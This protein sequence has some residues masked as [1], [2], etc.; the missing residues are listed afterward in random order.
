[1]NLSPNHL[2]DYTQVTEEDFNTFLDKYTPNYCKIA[3]AYGENYKN[4]KNIIF[5]TRIIKKGFYINNKYI[6][7]E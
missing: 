1:M 5:A 3:H 6:G 4:D 2:Y 7:K